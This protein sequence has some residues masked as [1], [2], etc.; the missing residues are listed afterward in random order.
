VA[1]GVLFAGCA[2]THV[3]EDA[4][5]R[6]AAADVRVPALDVGVDAPE[7]AGVDAFRPD[8]YSPFEH[9]P[10]RP[11][12]PDESGPPRSFALRTPGLSHPDDWASVAFDLD[13]EITEGTSLVCM[14]P[15]DAPSV[16]DGARGE[17]NAFALRLMPVLA[18]V[19][20]E[21]EEEARRGTETAPLVLQLD[22]WNGRADDP[23][24]TVWLAHAMPGETEPRWD[25]TDRWSLEDSDFVE[26]APDRP[27]N[28]DDNA[29]VAGG[30][31][32]AELPARQ[33]FR[34]QAPGG[35][36]L[37][38]RLTQ[39]RVVATLEEEALG[40]VTLTGRFASIDLDFA[41]DLLGVCRDTPDYAVLQGE[42]ARS[43][44]VRSTPGSGG[45]G[46][47]CDALSVG[48]DFRA[49]GAE[50]GSIEPATLP[51]SLCD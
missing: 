20:P 18:L 22:G 13:H 46:A 51:V 50:V 40:G 2:D 5:V 48:I 11:M 14:P 44:D 39:T 8:A 24:V 28:Q 21:M 4:E 29:S 23:R 12:V 17:D 36:T 47:T 7:D 15:D 37:E 33:S 19:S 41:L 30:R 6:D 16:P 42:I 45:P 25:G 26:G 32:V 1:W 9:P 38:F 10:A 27:I 43:Q 49:T 31:L 3:E 35:G 34:L